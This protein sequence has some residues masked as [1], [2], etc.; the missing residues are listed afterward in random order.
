M[1]IHIKDET[2]IRCAK[3]N[4]AIP[5]KLLTGGEAESRKNMEDAQLIEL[6]DK[7][8]KNPLRQAVV[9]AKQCGV[10]FV[11]EKLREKQKKSRLNYL[12]YVKEDQEHREF[13]L[14]PQNLQFIVQLAPLADGDYELTQIWFISSSDYYP[15]CLLV[16]FDNVEERKRFSTL[17]ERLNWKDTDLCKELIRDFMNKHERMV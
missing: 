3:S 5:N 15:E 13:Y 9:G 17:A 12:V 14:Q 16:C 6:F 4:Y 11:R 8:W 7:V 10:E 2:K 1:E